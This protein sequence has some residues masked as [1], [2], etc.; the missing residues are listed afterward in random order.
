[1]YR[2]Y[3]NCSNRVATIRS[4]NEV[5]VNTSDAEAQV[6][7]NADMAKEKTTKLFKA[8]Q[9]YKIY[10]DILFNQ[11][12]IEV[13]Y[14]VAAYGFAG[15]VLSCLV[16]SVILLVPVHNVIEE[17]QYWYVVMPGYTMI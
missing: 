11:P 13:S 9:R 14:F 16:T 3:N 15:V 6:D 2:L 8:D 17:P 4:I 10:K 12:T 7:A 1:M 5:E